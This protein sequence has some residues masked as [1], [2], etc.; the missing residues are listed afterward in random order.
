MNDHPVIAVIGGGSAGFT[1]ARTATDHGARVVWF[2]GDRG[3]RASLCINEGCMPSKA[4]FAP[5]DELHRA[6]R[7]S[8]LRVEPRDPA[9][10]LADIIA[11]K[12]RKIAGFRAFRRRQ[13]AGLAGPDCTVVEA[14]AR[15]V[16]AH[17]LAAG[18]QQYRADAI[19]L[20]TGSQPVFPPIDGLEVLRDRVWINEDILHNITLPRSLAVIGG[21]PLG[22]EFALRYARLGV[23]VVILS[24]S[25][26]L[27]TAPAA[28]GERL[29]TLY[30]RE[31]IRIRTGRTVRCLRC[32]SAGWLVLDTDDRDL[33]PIAVERVLLAAGRVPC[34]ATLN[35]A[36]ATIAP[37]EAGGLDVGPDLRVAG[38]QHVFAAGDIL[39][40]RHMVVHQAHRQAEIAA[41]NA[42]TGEHRAWSPGAHL[43]VVFSDPEFAFTGVTAEEARAAGH[44]VLAAQVES[45]EVGKLVIAGDESGFGQV[46]ADAPTRRLL[47]AGLLCHDASELIHVFAHAIAHGPTL[48][49]LAAAEWYHPTQAEIIPALLAPL[50]PRR[51]H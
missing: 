28:F 37:T 19:I 30:E 31:G 6:R 24:R 5:I 20:A 16:D 22:L 43:R 7:H 10:C 15:F 38:Q 33:D 35:L 1:A 11:W 3:E 34:L 29:A 36:A 32:D 49:Q 44:E 12:D 41:T 13:I 4:M 50:Q 9:T 45:R 25:R 2:L 23:E 42:V 51:P 17:T 26:L 18:R 46:I 47:G 39:G 48:D 27:A 21:G 40:G 8:W 14:S